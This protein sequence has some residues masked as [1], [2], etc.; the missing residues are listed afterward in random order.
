MMGSV[1]HDRLAIAVLVTFLTAICAFARFQFRRRMLDIAL[2]CLLLVGTTIVL[3]GWRVVPWQQ[4]SAG[5]DFDDRLASQMVIALWWLMLPLTVVTSVRTY[6]SSGA[7]LHEKRFLVDVVATAVYAVSIVAVVTNV[8]GIPIKGVLATSGA[9]AIVLGL[10][11]QSTLADL[12]SGLLINATSPYRVGDTIALDGD[13]EGEVIEISWRAT[14]I[15]N[16]RKDMVVVPNSLIAKTKIINK[17]FPST[18]HAQVA[19]YSTSSMWPPDDVIHALE[20]ATETCVGIARNPPPIVAA[21]SVGRKSQHYDITFFLSGERKSTGV[22]NRFYD[23]AH[24]HLRA[25]KLRSDGSSPEV[26]SMLVD[27]LIASLRVF[28]YLTTNQRS[29]LASTLVRREWTPGHVILRSGEVSTG[30]FIIAVGIIGLTDRAP[31]EGA[32]ILRLGPLEYFGEGGPIAG[33]ASGVT[34]VT[35]SYAI[36]YELPFETVSA[37]LGRH[38]DV[39]HA[40]ASKLA[41]R[42]RTGHLLLHSSTSEGSPQTHGLVSWLHR[43]IQSLHR[44]ST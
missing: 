9:F 22:M 27:E 34:Y 18:Q 19:R 26:H 24:R 7:R 16:D 20:M 1:L 12:F 8:F 2:K 32:D 5:V 15:A 3:I 28:G 23:A 41:T 43:C 6:Y 39:A 37:L 21:A 42:Q 25:Q 10:A 11:L 35:R 30:L 40:L 44:K 4:L 31:E 33:L 36:G 14:H 17:S 29:E 13:T 38:S